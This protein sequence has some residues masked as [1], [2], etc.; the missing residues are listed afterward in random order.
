MT[1]YHSR[2]RDKNIFHL[3]TNQPMPLSRQINCLAGIFGPNATLVMEATGVFPHLVRLK[4]SVLTC[5]PYNY[6]KEGIKMS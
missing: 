1:F 6:A 2:L 5:R 3:L 4:F